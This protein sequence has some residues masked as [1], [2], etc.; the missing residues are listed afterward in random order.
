MVQVGAALALLPQGIVD[1]S[2]L[3]PRVREVDHPDVRVGAAFDEHARREVLEPLVERYHIAQNV[4]CTLSDSGRL[5]LLAG[6]ACLER[7]GL[8]TASNG[9]KL[10]A[11]RRDDTG[12]VF[13]SSFTHHEGAMQNVSSRAK[14]DVIDRIRKRFAALGVAG[15]SEVLDAEARDAIAADPGRGRRVALQLTLDVHCQIA[16]LV[17]ARGPNTYVS[18]A[19]ASTTSAIQ[20]ATN[21]IQM[22]DAR[23]MLVVGS[24][25]VLGDA[26]PCVVR[27]FVELGAATDARAVVDAVKPFSARRN[28]FTMGEGA[29]ALLLERHDLGEGP[30]SPSGTSHPPSQRVSIAASRIA[31]SAYHGTA[32]DA[33]HIAGTLRRCVDDARGKVSLPDFASRCLYVSHE[34]C[35]RTCAQ[36]EIEALRSVFGDATRRV[37]ITNTKCYTGHAMGAC[38]EDVAAVAAL[39]FQRAPRVLVQQLDHGF[40]DLRFCDD[41]TD[42]G[43]DFA[44]HTAL[45]MGSHVA[46]VI[47]KRC[48]E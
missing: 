23:R 2:D 29:V 10:D 15:V 41:R 36:K 24:D 1:G 48:W 47:Y 18:N 19:C 12:V 40:E 27:S 9:W 25:A 6:M 14:C 45:G 22:G 44:I 28:G 11:D 17:G 46:I 35:T 43:F 30:A 5:G 7:A 16:Q 26:T 34:T 31:N 39:K 4:L 42:E 33:E 32:L 3:T 13:A 37:R 20:L 8:I 38:V 21:A